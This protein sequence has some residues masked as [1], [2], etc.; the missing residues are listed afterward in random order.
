M[1]PTT[2]TQGLPR[3][4]LFK[5]SLAVGAGLAS[6]GGLAACGSSSGSTDIRFLENKPE[7]IPYFDKLTTKFNTAQ[8]RVVATHDPTTTPLTPQFVR[9]A[10]PDLACYNFQ[11]E[12]ASF[13]ARGALSNLADLPQVK[14]IQPSILDLVSQFATYK[15]QTNVIPYSVAAA[16]VIYNK[17]LFE[18]HDVAVPTTWPEMIAA[19]KKFKAAGVVPIYFTLLDGWTLNQGVWDYTSG[20]SLDIGDFFQRLKAE[21]GGVGPNSK[22]SFSKDF[23][24]AAHKMVEL[25]QYRNP[26]A[27]SVGY[28]AGNT[29]FAK[30]KAAMIFQGPWALTPLG[31]AAPDLELGTFAL[32]CTDSA[33]DR[34]VR[35]NLDLALW[36][37]NDSPHQAAARKMLEWLMQPEIIYAYNKDA[38]ATA[39]TIDAPALS[40]PRVSGISSY[41][42]DGKFYQG[43]ATFI[44]STIPLGNY[45]QTMLSTG[46]VTGTLRRLDQDW[47]NRAARA[48]AA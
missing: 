44:S 30:G 2:A 31:A 20:G 16:A 37:P 48:A 8:D 26:N 21:A 25:Y 45:L 10:P 36:I 12:A 13:L 41:V 1:E 18:K 23:A 15:G 14:Q 38:L 33:G 4:Q 40:D 47:A 32:P 7:V 28:N 34:K 6:S 17:A 24:D 29:E 42:S 5:W 19:C 11:L 27:P 43:A 46:D 22:T 35:V 9:G 39:P 3:R